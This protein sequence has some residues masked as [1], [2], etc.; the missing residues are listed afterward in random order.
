MEE[1]FIIELSTHNP[2][3]SLMEIILENDYEE[4]GECLGRAWC[5]TCHVS[6]DRIDHDAINSNEIEKDE[7]MALDLLSNR[8]PNSR[9]GC[10]I[11]IDKTLD[12]ATL[13]YLGDN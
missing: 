11:I 3:Q 4:W 5:R 8:K 2:L 7:A 1:Q 10:Q 6:L 12:G 13:T 9:L